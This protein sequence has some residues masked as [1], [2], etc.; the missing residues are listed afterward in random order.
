MN[1]EIVFSDVIDGLKVSYGKI[2]RTPDFYIYQQTYGSNDNNSYPKKD[3]PTEVY[4]NLDTVENEINNWSYWGLLIS[5]Y[6]I[7]YSSYYGSK[8]YIYENHFNNDEKN[9]VSDKD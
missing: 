1:H 9:I 5:N 2:W 6:K 7:N 3:L 8:N 4:F